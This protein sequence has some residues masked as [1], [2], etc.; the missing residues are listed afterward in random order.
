M[1]GVDEIP[2]APPPSEP[3]AWRYVDDHQATM[4]FSQVVPVNVTVR[5]LEVRIKAPKSLGS[6]VKE[7]LHIGGKEKEMLTN[8]E[9]GKGP[10]DGLGGKTIIRGISAD[11]PTGTLS[12]IIGGSGSGKVR[13]FHRSPYTAVIDRI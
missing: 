8:A 4:S 9:E 1:S 13:F 12:A 2:A 5:D 10:E 7:G 11:F 3:E 6:S